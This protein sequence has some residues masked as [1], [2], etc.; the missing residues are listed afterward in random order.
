MFVDNYSVV[1][2]DGEFDSPPSPP[3][4]KCVNCNS[5]NKRVKNYIGYNKGKYPIYLFRTDTSGE[6]AYE[7][8]YTEE[9]NLDLNKYDYLGLIETNDIEICFKNVINDFEKVFQ[10]G[11]SSKSSSVKVLNKYVPDFYHI[12]TGKNLDQKM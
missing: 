5:D 11:I 9:E 1:Y 7:E 8:F 6:K 2:L 12:E 3:L 10:K 4:I